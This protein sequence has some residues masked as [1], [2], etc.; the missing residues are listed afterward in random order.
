[1]ARNIRWP[2]MD[3]NSRSLGQRMLRQIVFYLSVGRNAIVV[4]IASIIAFSLHG[5]DQPFSLT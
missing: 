3:P 1:A 5:E 4:F 2:C